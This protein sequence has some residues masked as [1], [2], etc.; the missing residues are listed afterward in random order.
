[1]SENRTL[2]PVL[3]SAQASLT[4]SRKTVRRG[5]GGSFLQGVWMEPSTMAARSKALIV[6]VRSN[7][8]IVGSNPT[9]GMDVCVCPVFV[10]F[11]V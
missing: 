2:D 7:A 3:K 11:R 4:D 6:F 8:G 1:M 9:E 5:E 10:L